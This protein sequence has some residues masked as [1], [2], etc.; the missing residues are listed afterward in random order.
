MMSVTTPV[1][2]SEAV[3]K[4][5]ARIVRESFDKD[6]MVE[7]NARNATP[8]YESCCATHD[9]CDANELMA[10]AFVE[11]LGRD[12]EVC[13]EADCLVW[14]KAWTLAKENGFYVT[15]A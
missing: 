2:T 4:T 10:E 7:V 12:P 15:N 3:A 6:Q 8:E 14:N 11:I 1:E 13:D 5:F 9:F